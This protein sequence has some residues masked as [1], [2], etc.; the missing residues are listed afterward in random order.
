VTAQ[1]QQN[2]LWEIFS[3][4]YFEVT[5]FTYS[6]QVEVAG[7]SFTDNPVIWQHAEPVQVDIPAGRIKYLN[8]ALLS[9]PP[10]PPDQVATVNQYIL[11][12]AALGGGVGPAATA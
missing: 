9:L 4:Q 3:D 1:N 6:I 11:G 8:P 5:S 12:Y 10:C 2:I 7:P